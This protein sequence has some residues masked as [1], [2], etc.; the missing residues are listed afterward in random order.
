MFYDSDGS[1]TF[2]EAEDFEDLNGNLKWDRAEYFIDSNNNDIYDLN[3]ILYD[4]DPNTGLCSD[5]TSGYPND[6]SDKNTYHP[7]GS[8]EIPGNDDD[9]SCL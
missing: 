6:C 9:R 5:C 4:C 7:F 3:E 1:L 8:D 2:E